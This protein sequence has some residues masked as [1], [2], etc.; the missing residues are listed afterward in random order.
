M[1]HSAISLAVKKKVPTVPKALAAL[2]AMERELTAA[3]T[4]DDIR[5]IIKEATALKVLLG[6][7]DEVKAQAEDTI[8]VASVRVGEEIKKVPKASGGSKLPGRVNLK[9]GRKGVGLPGTSR[10]R[11]VKLADH[12]TA[13]AKSAAKALRAQGKDATPRAV[14]TFLTQGDK[15]ERRAERERQL[16]ARQLAMPTGKFNVI[17][18]DDEQDHEVYSRETGMDRHASNHY[19]TST[20]AHTAAE[21][22]ERTKA[23][24]EC[25]AGDCVLFQWSTVQHLDIMIDLLRLRGFQYVSHYVWGKDKIGLG[26]W[27]RNK[28]ELLLIGTRGNIPCPAPGTQWDSLITAPRGEH[29]AKPECFL[30]MIEQYFPSLPKIELN[31][32][33]TARSGWSAWGDEVEP[34]EAAE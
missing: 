4:Y 3:K 2:A 23:R 19:P 16:G 10:S 7:I 11:L 34:A 30:E 13:A 28:H 31:R 24:F 25:A 29:S 21:M 26:Y 17:V 27:N 6:H 33:G 18:V 15:K 8:L 12:G 20:D 14:A 1:T 22:H 9:S 5:R 32:R